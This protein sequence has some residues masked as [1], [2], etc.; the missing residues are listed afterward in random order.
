MLATVDDTPSQKI[1]DGMDSITSSF[2]LAKLAKYESKD[3]ITRFLREETVCKQMLKSDRCQTVDFWRYP[4]TAGT[5]REYYNCKCYG[6]SP[7]TRGIE[8]YS[9]L[10]NYNGPSRAIVNYQMGSS[11]CRLKPKLDL[12]VIFPGTRDQCVSRCA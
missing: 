2:P 11:F 6:E 5:D 4:K 12:S 8:D 1:K 10:K 3:Q 7:L 9:M